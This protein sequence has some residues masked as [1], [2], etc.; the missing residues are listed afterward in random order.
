MN[1]SKKNVGRASPTRGDLSGRR[2]GKLEVICRSDKRG[3]RGAR[4]VPLWEC[5]CDCGNTVYKATDTLNRSP[6]SMCSAC[7]ADYASS[8]MR[9]AAGYVD[10]T[11]ISRIKSEHL[12]ASNT[13]GARGVY[14]DR[15]TGKWRARLKFKGKLMD[16]GTYTDFEDAVRARKEAEQTYYG[17]FLD[18]LPSE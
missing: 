7:A 16:F 18:S 14:K 17:E 15:V 9:A 12:I 3:S 6:N 2:F 11:Q 4:T 5:R 10:G 8:Q 1:E 13:S